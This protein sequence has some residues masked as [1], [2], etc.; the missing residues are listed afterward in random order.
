MMNRSTT[1]LRKT[2]SLLLGVL[3]VYSS[4]SAQSPVALAEDVSAQYR[5]DQPGKKQVL[6]TQWLKELESSYAINFGY[7]D[8][9]VKD[10]YVVP[11]TEKS[12]TLEERLDYVLHPHQ[13]RYQKLNASFYLIRSADAKTKAVPKL[14]RNNPHAKEKSALTPP[15]NLLARAATG[16]RDITVLEQNVS[17]TVTDEANEPLPGVNVLV[18]NTTVG[19]VTDIDGNY[20]L[21]APDDATTLVFS[22]VGYTVMEVEINGRSTI[23]VSL[24]PDV[25]ELGEVVVTALG[26]KKEAKKLGYAT[27]TVEPE[28]ITVNRTTNFMNALQGKIAGVNISS[29]ATGSAGTSKIRIRGQSS[30][31]GQNSPLIVVNGVPIDN[32]NFGVT[33]GNRGDDAAIGNRTGNNSDGGDGL[34]SINPDD[35]E[36]MTVLKGAAAAALYGA[37][38]KDGVIM[39]TTKNRGEGNGLG[40]QWNTNFTAETPLDYTDYQYE[41]GQGE[42][43]VRPTAANPT[44]GVWSFGERFEPGMTQILFDGIEVP[45]EPVRDRISKFYRTG[46]SITNTLTLSA[47]SDKGG[48][49]LSLANLSN[50]SFVPNSEFARRTVNLGFVYDITPKLNVSGNI[51]Y[52]IEDNQNPPIVVQQNISTPVVLYTLSNSMPLDV[53]EANRLNENGDEFIWSRF[54][55]RT[56]PYFSINERFENVRRDRIFGNV[57]LRYNFTDWLYLQGRIGQDYWSRDQE[58]NFPTGQ[59]SIPPAPQGFVNGTYVQESRRFR[60]INADFLIG[61]TQEFGA[62]GVN[63][64]LGGN[65]MYRRSDRNSVRVTDFVIRDLYT[66]QNG[67]VK[68][69][70]YTLAERQVNSLY[71]ALE[72]SYKDYLFLNMTARNDW[73]STLAPENRSILYPSVTGSF[74]F[75]QVFTNFPEWINFGKVRAGYAEVGSDTDVAPY[76]DNLFYSVN[77]N[78]FPN[79]DGQLLPLG[80]INTNTVPNANLRPMRVAETEVGLEMRMFESRVNFD[81]TYY[82]KLTTDQI[83]AAQISD[84]SG[85]TS[86]LINVGESRTYGVELML[87]VVPVQTNNFRWDV[88]F[89]GAYNNSEVLKLGSDPEDTVITV[90]RGI[91]GVNVRQVVGKPM[92]QIYGFRYRRDDQGRIVY[93]GN[94]GRPLRTTEQTSFGTAIPLWFGG[95]TNGFQYKNLSFSFL[96]DFKLGHKMASGTNFNVWRHGL[97]RATLEGREQGF[98]VGDGVNENGEVNT[99]QTPIQT[100]YESIGANNIHEIYIYNAGFW[101]LRQV[102]LGYDF[103]SMLPDDFFIKGLRLNAIANNVLLLKKWVPNIHPEQLPSASDNLVG[104]EQ[105]SLP[106]TRSIGFN[107]NV[108]F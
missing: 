3:W 10:K 51:N 92:G 65:Q 7:A 28:E 66:V 95:I 82:N 102:T 108:K 59:A 81:L 22:S 99:V 42:G 62:L 25:T 88:T 70:L 87:N 84:V 35:I 74:V 11:T 50:E 40:V 44:S 20:Q 43:G 47:G 16:V 19:T 67:R 105:S 104:M 55:N 14:E 37:R 45:Y 106:L 97:H 98:V 86:N 26:I 31:A 38:A 41:Y 90:G 4:V 91:G 2:L 48:F 23:N 49:N 93:S 17:G 18:K 75:S 53:L 77:N 12:A 30:F 5:P 1:F 101:Q 69:P 68:D 24:S 33:A 89:N 27:A 61:A 13:L 73:F 32:S 96:I 107:L 103:T 56:N 94:N 46:T 78:L 71:G 21:T 36:S 54:R 79:S 64:T 15:T 52:S 60:E 6:L 39:I 58:Y 9:D 85:Y 72:L 34:S 83:L 80:V 100:F 57:T 29:Q 76:S 8:Q 63:L